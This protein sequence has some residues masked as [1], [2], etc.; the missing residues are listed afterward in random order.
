M[1]SKTLYSSESGRIECADHAPYRGSDTWRFDR[2]RPMGAAEQ[3]DFR[4]ALVGVI[5]PDEPLCEVC[6]GIARRAK[7]EAAR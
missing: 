2:Y 3:A 6:R 4:A 1:A 5:G 7:A